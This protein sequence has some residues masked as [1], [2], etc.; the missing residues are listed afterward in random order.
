ME[1][2]GGSDPPPAVGESPPK[3]LIEGALVEALEASLPPGAPES[4]RKELLSDLQSLLEDDPHLSAQIAR[5]NLETQ[6]D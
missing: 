5:A 4:L 1:A 2:A 6:D 3:Q